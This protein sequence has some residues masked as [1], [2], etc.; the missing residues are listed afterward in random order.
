MSRVTNYVRWKNLSEGEQETLRTKLLKRLLK[1]PGVK[2]HFKVTRERRKD[3]QDKVHIDI[4]MKSLSEDSSAKAVIHADDS[5]Q[6]KACLYVVR[7]DGYNQKQTIRYIIR[8]DETFNV[9]KA[10][11]RLL[12][13]NQWSID[14]AARKRHDDA[15]ATHKRGLKKQA[16][17]ELTRLLA[18]TDWEVHDNWDSIRISPKDEYQPRMDIKVRSGYEPTVTFELGEVTGDSK[19]NSKNLK[20]IT[21]LLSTVLDVIESEEFRAGLKESPVLA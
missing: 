19:A 20:R 5:Y 6:D 3:W 4:E 9:E 18:D 2:E 15:S 7:D 12:E 11:A 21:K 16:I 8:E 17:K 13:L 10:A 1:E 14:H